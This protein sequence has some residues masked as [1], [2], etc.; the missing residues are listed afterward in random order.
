MYALFDQENLSLLFASENGFAPQRAAEGAP[1][2]KG[3]LNAIVSDYSR[4]VD[5]A[6]ELI[7]YM[8][9]QWRQAFEPFE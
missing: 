7:Q 2:L 9:L 4:I 3:A 1:I 5:I 8:H 6:K